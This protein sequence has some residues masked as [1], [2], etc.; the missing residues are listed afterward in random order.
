MITPI[1]I[2]VVALIAVIWL[3]HEFKKLNHKI[4]AIFLILLIVFTYFSFSSAIKGKE[5]DLKSAVGMKEAG[6][7]YVLWLGNAFNNIKIITGNAIHMNWKVNE[8]LEANI[9]LK[10]KEQI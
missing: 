5:I 9:S 2:L 4:V 1:L 8:S 10:D 7:L 3:S 6:Q